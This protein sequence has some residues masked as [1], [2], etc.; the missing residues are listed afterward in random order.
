[1]T[2]GPTPEFCLLADA[3]VDLGAWRTVTTARRELG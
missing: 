3:P 2:L 1:M